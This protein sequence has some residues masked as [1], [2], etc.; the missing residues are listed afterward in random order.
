M[1]N[2]PLLKFIALI[3]LGCL[4]LVL[5]WLMSAN[6]MISRLQDGQI[7]RTYI[8]TAG[9]LGPVLIILLMVVAVMV[10]P[11]PSAPIALAAGAAY[12]H[13][14]GTIFILVGSVLGA[15]G[16][17]YVARYLGFEFVQ[18]SARNYFSSKLLKSQNALMGIVLVSRLMP[19][20][21]FD[22]I[23]YAAGLTNLA[24]WR[25]ALATIIGIAPASF[26]LAHVGSE[27]V[28]S[29]L[30]E[31]AAALALLAVLVAGSLLVNLTRKK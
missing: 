24:F 17:F 27:M 21:S 23:S 30:K 8:E 29:E 18:K 25:F 1:K 10:S 16:A 7:I 14:W 3:A 2:S 13:T 11:I 19:F 28:S 9:Y 4:G 5:Y 26:I 22:I 15:T 12:G 31:I 20:L 6:N